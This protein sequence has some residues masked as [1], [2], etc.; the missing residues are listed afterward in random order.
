MRPGTITA[1]TQLTV[2]V[3]AT[4]FEGTRAA[5][6]AAIPLARGSGARL[7]LL[8]PQVVPYPLPVD[9]PVDSTAFTADRYRDLVHELDGEA[10][11][12]VCLC[13]HADDVIWQML[14]SQ[15]AVV[16]GGSAGTWR[17]SREERLERRLAHLGYRVV[18]APIAER[19]VDDGAPPASFTPGPFD[20]RSMGGILLLVVTLD[21]IVWWSTNRGVW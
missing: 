21:A 19:R 13:R 14:P 7:A 16:V 20:L 4:T 3:V 1:A 10:D 2:Y 15:A 17:A 9:G 11:I 18:F 8:V 12:R 5:L 6:A